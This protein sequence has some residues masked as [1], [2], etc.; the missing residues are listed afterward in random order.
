ML[1]TTNRLQ[2]HV[3]VCKLD[4]VIEVMFDVMTVEEIETLEQFWLQKSA[5]VS[6]R[7]QC[8]A[9]YRLTQPNTLLFTMFAGADSLNNAG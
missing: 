5:C 1:N 3:N 6:A 7:L 2:Q 8:P 9:H 4:E